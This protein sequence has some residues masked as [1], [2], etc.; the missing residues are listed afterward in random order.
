[1][2]TAYPEITNGM[3]AS[4]AAITVCY[5]LD[6]LKNYMQ[7]NFHKET[8]QLRSL[9]KGMPWELTSNLPSTALFWGVY[10]HLRNAEQSPF[11]SVLCASTCSNVIDT[12]FDIYKKFRQLQIPA[13][14]SRGLMYRFGCLNLVQSTLYNSIYM[15]L[16]H[17][18]QSAGVPKIASIITCCTTASI[19]TYPI[20][21]WK[22]KLVTQKPLAPFLKGLG[23][24]LLYGNFYSGL[25]MYLVLTLQ[26]GKI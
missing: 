15:P 1:M 6:T 2:N 17:R 23:Y 18:L 7:T 5:P 13:Q 8:L 12:P 14:I 4:T 16:L 26:Q 10:Y 25:Y 19:I 24:R 11:I 21:R 20:D 9:Y 3:I 22:T